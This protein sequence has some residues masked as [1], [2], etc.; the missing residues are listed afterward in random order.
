MITLG[1]IAN[2]ELD[3][4]GAMTDDELLGALEAAPQQERKAFIKG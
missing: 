4:M 2:S 3:L 1:A